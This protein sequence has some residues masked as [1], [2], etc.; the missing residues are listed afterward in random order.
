MLPGWICW[1]DYVDFED[2]RAFAYRYWLKA[3]TLNTDE[4]KNLDEDEK[5]EISEG[6]FALLIDMGWPKKFVLEKY[7]AD[8]QKL[9]Y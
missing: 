2:E 5:T 4:Y 9:F 8:Q 6:L 1:F 7:L 3:K